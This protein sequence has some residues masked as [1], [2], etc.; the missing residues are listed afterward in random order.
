MDKNGNLSLRE[1]LEARMEGR[2]PIRGF[3]GR[4]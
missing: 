3:D 4:M 2:L 1:E